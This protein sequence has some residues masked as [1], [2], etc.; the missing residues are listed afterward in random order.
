VARDGFIPIIGLNEFT[1]K[2]QI[3]DKHTQSNRP[4]AVFVEGLEP[5]TLLL[6][7]FTGDEAISTLF[8]YRLEVLVEN[9]AQV[10]FEKILGKSVTVELEL[11]GS[12]GPREKKRYFHGICQRVTQG[13][14]DE[15]FTHF[16]LDVVPSVWLLTKIARS[17]VFQDVS[18]PN[19]IHKLVK[20]VAPNGAGSIFDTLRPNEFESRDYCVQ[21]RETDFN[22]ASRLMAEEGLRYY[23]R[24]NLGVKGLEGFHHIKV[25][26]D[27]QSA[28]DWI[29]QESEAGSRVFYSMEDLKDWDDPAPMGQIR[30]W[31]K[32]QELRS[33]KV[34]LRD[35]SFELPN[36][37][38]ESSRAT[39]PN[40]PVGMVSHQLN[41][42]NT[43]LEL[44]D[45]PGQYAKR[46]DGINKGGG[47]QPQKLSEVFKS[48]ERV[49][50]IRMEQETT[51]AVTIHGE[52][53]CR[54]F[55]AGYLFG[56]VPYGK[57]EEQS[58]AKG[59][60]R[61]VSVQHEFGFPGNHASGDNRGFYYRNNFS[62]VPAALSYR[63]ARTVSKP[64]IAGM[65]TGLVV[66]PKD[67]E[68]YTD[69]YGRVKVQF[70]WD[71]EGKKDLESSCW[72]RVGQFWAGKR[73]GAHF[74]PRVGQEVIVAFVEGDPDQPIIVGSVYN[75]E[76]MP[77]YDMPKHQTRSGIKSHSTPQS[78]D[79]PEQFNEIRFEDKKGAEELHV[80]AERNLTVLV[81]DTEYLNIGCDRVT[82]INGSC[83][84]GV[85]KGF[86]ESANDAMVTE[87]EN[88][89]YHLEVKNGKYHLGAATV[90]DIQ[91]NDAAYLNAKNHVQVWSEKNMELVAHQGEMFVMGTEQIA[92]VCGKGKIIIKSDGSIFISGTSVN[93][94]SSSGPATISPNDACSGRLGRLA[95]SNA[96]LQGKCSQNGQAVP[97]ANGQASTGH[98]P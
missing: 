16:I 36:A 39:Q 70:F 89:G 94:N 62:C 60:Y 90:V 75:A 78:K 37:N 65:Q 21:Y 86:K 64:V 72:I 67:G 49:A 2:E 17:R 52:S 23:F 42:L 68:V 56:V 13:E 53:T 83:Y 77:P 28:P 40:V 91:S 58:Q 12:K 8:H 79:H 22:F 41:G 66:G 96:W 97:A 15:H 10:P 76:N 55:T 30:S 82:H 25:I 54:L 59:V 11:P 69:K 32:T 27:M 73:W 92:L 26:G 46:F 38:L 81:K 34:T 1:R 47:E 84:L 48:A 5:D 18:V 71:R 95:W 51:A 44:Y 3:M 14:T 88:G 74:W 29:Y 57:H 4:L 61:L 9:P 33:G 35:H 93:I 80:Q 31:Q 87:V 24:Q 7:R 20:P 19:I 63:P 45:Y 43:N 50:R 85:G 6:V 98:S